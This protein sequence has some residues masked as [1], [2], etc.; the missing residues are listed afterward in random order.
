[1]GFSTDILPY[2]SPV[3]ELGMLFS[4]FLFLGLSLWN[5]QNYGGM[6]CLT[7]FLGFF[8]TGSTIVIAAI[9]CDLGKNEILKNNKKALAT[10]SGIIDGFAGFGSVIG[11]VS[12]GQVESVYGW[13]ATFSMLTIVSFL[14][15]LPASF[16]VFDE[17]RHWRLRKQEE[18][19]LSSSN[20]S[21]C[22]L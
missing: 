3:F 19:R 14:S 10:V 15:T 17:F 22:K 20:G 7:F 1:M 13:K 6:A 18:E 11:Q 21:E 4:S 5:S 2:R 8:I 9:E 16:F 12:I